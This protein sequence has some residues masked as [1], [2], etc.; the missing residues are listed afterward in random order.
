MCVAWDWV[1]EYGLTKIDKLTAIHAVDIF[2]PEALKR[3]CYENE[4]DHIERVRI[5]QQSI[6]D[7]NDLRN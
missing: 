7:G 5:F 3:A 1:F 6:I 2:V 4:V